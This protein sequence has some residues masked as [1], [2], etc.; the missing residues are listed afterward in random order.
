MMQRTAAGGWN[1][2]YQSP[3]I[4]EFLPTKGVGGWPDIVLGGPGFCFPVVRYNG[5][6]YA[7]HRQKEEQPGA[8]T[9][10]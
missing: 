5:K 4:P 9:R 8:C 10:R 7:N 1:T 3:G 6:T 2:L